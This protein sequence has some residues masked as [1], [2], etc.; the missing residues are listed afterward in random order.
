MENKGIA[1]IAIAAV[2]ILVGLSFWSTIGGSIGTLTVIQ[3]S[4]NVS[5]TLPANNTVAD[6]TPCGQKNTSTVVIYDATGAIILPA[7]NY[8]VA[9]GTSSTDGYL[10]D[11][12]TLKNVNATWASHAA[13]VS[14][15]YQPR[16]Y[17]TDSGSRSI[18]NLI[19]IFFALL[20]AIVALPDVRERLKDF[21]GV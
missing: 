10:A 1:F 13:N 6:L 20:I 2:V 18:V 8:S 3:S 21:A 19:P 14:C 4:A 15:S 9:Q 12:I 5:Y 7:T 11:Q 16:G 17:V